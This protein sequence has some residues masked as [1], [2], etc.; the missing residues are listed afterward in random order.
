MTAEKLNRA[1]PK[2]KQDHPK[3]NKTTSNGVALMAMITTRIAT[4]T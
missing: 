2:S 4:A 1:T 3:I